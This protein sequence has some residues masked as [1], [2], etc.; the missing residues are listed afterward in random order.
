MFRRYTDA[1][2]D[3]LKIEI[4][5]SDYL[6]I[7]VT[8]GMSFYV[9]FDV[10]DEWLLFDEFQLNRFRY[11]GPVYVRPQTVDTFTFVII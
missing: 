11:K 1:N 4:E 7:E 9:R 8:S 6:K 2:V 3:G 10:V 5:C